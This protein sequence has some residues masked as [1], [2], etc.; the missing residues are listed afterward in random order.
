M[1]A[2]ARGLHAAEHIWLSYRSGGSDTLAWSNGEFRFIHSTWPSTP[3]PG[4]VGRDLGPVQA[5]YHGQSRRTLHADPRQ[6]WY[7]RHWRWERPRGQSVQRV[8]DA[9]TVRSHF[10]LRPR[11]PFPLPD[12]APLSSPRPPASGGTG[13]PN[14]EGGRGMLAAFHSST[15]THPLRAPFQHH[16]E[17]L[18]S[19]PP[20]PP[21][22][23]PLAQHRHS[24]GAERSH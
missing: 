6:G 23:A 17:A 21:R 4:T 3:A 13:L 10:R 8:R 2:T 14:R 18:R 19:A 9:Q 11:E 20:P 22:L 5:W 1:T 7:R 24:A 15:T 12:V 16:P